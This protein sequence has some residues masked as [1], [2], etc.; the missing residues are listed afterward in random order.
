M[1][2]MTREG[3][4]EWENQVKSLEM[5]LGRGKFAARGR[6]VSSALKEGADIT[7]RKGR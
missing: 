6:V 4:E 3:F 1:T 5:Y 7:C 2:L